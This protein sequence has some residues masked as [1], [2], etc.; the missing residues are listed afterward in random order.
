[1]G[2]SVARP[3]MSRSDEPE[4]SGKPGD[5]NREPKIRVE[6]DLDDKSSESPSGAYPKSYG[7][8]ERLWS[9][10]SPSQ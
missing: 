8:G 3:S 2:V 7:Y 9:F 6:E 5:A 10:L 4:Q 1:M